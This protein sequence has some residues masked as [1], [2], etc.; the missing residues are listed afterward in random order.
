MGDPC[1]GGDRREENGIR[2]FYSGYT[3]L[4]LCLSLSAGHTSNPN[5]VGNHVGDNMRSTECRWS[6]LNS[7]QNGKLVSERVNQH[8]WKRMPVIQKKYKLVQLFLPGAAPLD[9]LVVSSSSTDLWNVDEKCWQPF[10]QVRRSLTSCYV[11]HHKMILVKAFFH[12]PHS[13][14]FRLKNALEFGQR[15][16]VQSSRVRYKHLLKCFA[17][18]LLWGRTVWAGEASLVSLGRADSNVWL[19]QSFH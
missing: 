7:I 11:S 3:R 10:L 16:G 9:G 12:M 13:K 6:T 15:W 2:W 8:V 4:L 19:I 5:I 1:L 14:T 17:K 18:F